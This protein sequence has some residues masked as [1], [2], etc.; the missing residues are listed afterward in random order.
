MKKE[1][2]NIMVAVDGSE[3]SYNAVQEAVEVTKRNG[4]KLQIVTV[5]DNKRYYGMAG[6]GFVETPGLDQ[7]A[8]EILNEASR[9]VGDKVEVTL[10]ELSGTPK[11]RIVSFSEEHNIDLIVIGSTGAGV[12]DKLMLGS[13]TQYVVSHAP[14]NVMV[15]K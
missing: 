15:I 2:K 9:L 8:Q 14:C 11:Y 1:Y 7:M 10:Q 5:K 4:G 13:T 12:I 3:Q 6:A